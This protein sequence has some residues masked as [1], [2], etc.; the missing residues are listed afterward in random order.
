LDG[1]D[2][3]DHFTVIVEPEEG[4]VAGANVTDGAA[5]ATAARANVAATRNMIHKR[6]KY[7]STNQ[8]TQRRNSYPL[9][10][11]VKT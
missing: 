1:D 3:P 6:V 4:N 8:R 7:H 5:N 10:L 2:T 11:G 9:S